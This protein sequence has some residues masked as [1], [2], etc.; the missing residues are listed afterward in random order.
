LK[1]TESLYGLN[2]DYILQGEH[3]IIFSGEE[4]LTCEDLTKLQVQMLQFNTVPHLLPFEKEEVNCEIRLLYRYTNKRM[5]THEIR[6]NPLYIMQYY[7]LILKI[8]TALVDSKV[9][10]LNEENYILH[11]DFIFV[12][13][14]YSDLYLCYLP[15]QSLKNKE[16][17]RE[18]LSSL[19]LNLISTVAEIK[20]QGFQ[21]F[22]KSLRDSN[23]SLNQLRQQLYKLIDEELQGEGLAVKQVKR[24]HENNED[25]L[26]NEVELEGDRP[27]HAKTKN[28]ILSNFRLLNKKFMGYIIALILIG[29]IIMFYV[30]YPS[31]GSLY[32]CLGLIVLII[33]ALYVMGKVWRSEKV[34]NIDHYVESSVGVIQDAIPP[35]VPVSQYYDE[36]PNHTSI[37]KKSD[38]T[39]YLHSSVKSE[40]QEPDTAKA[41]IQMGAKPG[42]KRIQVKGKRFV[43]GRDAS[44]ADLTI[45]SIG[46]SRI[47][48]EILCSENEWGI[49]DLGSNNGSYLNDE[50]LIPYKWTHLQDGDCIKV[51]RNEFVFHIIK[52]IYIN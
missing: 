37:L 14:D 52:N 8:V 27:E 32:I 45:D 17:I 50:A 41:Y 23:C 43:M 7:K 44:T 46:A 10:M 48:C 22:I 42:S 38:A 34:V 26:V 29:S 20:G 6:S 9:Y 3:F 16:T 2:Y 28:S 24:V 21:E 40:N 18:E 1:E 13:K 51:V 4:A 39:V 12:G 19:A 5:L 35:G 11:E 31:E 25:E 15:L 30:T 49:K 36:L 33:D 47:H